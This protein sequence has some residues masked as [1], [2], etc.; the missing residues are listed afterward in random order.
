[1]LRVMPFYLLTDSLT[2]LQVRLLWASK[3]YGDLFWHEELA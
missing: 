3:A 2:H 1:M